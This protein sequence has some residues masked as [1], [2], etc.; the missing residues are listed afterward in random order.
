MDVQLSEICDV[1]ESRKMPDGSEDLVP[2]KLVSMRDINTGG[3]T[4][5]VP[6]VAN[7]ATGK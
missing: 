6:I 4:I 1:P 3:Y 7:G 2:K 5:Q